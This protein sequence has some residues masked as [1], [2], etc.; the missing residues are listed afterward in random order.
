MAQRPLPPAPLRTLF[1]QVAARFP[2]H[3]MQRIRTPDG[4]FR[5]TYASPGMRETFGI[6]P[7]LVL[8]QREA[9]HSWVHPEDRGRF[10][11]ALHRSADH[12][13]TLDEEV[14][15]VGPDGGHKWVRSIGTPRRLADGTVVWDG[16]AL[17]VTERRAAAEAL[18]RAVV[19]ARAAEAARWEAERGAGAM[20]LASLLKLNDA[21]G[22][23]LAILPAE[24][25]R[26][27][28]CASVRESLARLMAQRVGAADARAPGTAPRLTPR[29]QTVLALL[30]AGLTNRQIAARLG[31]TEGTVK[32]HV[33]AVLKRLGV[34]NRTEAALRAARG[35]D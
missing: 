30:G 17:D 1:D 18:E 2:G 21:V 7:E 33:A 29:Q 32:L 34:S 35:L 3:T 4:R 20:P 12:L 11:T 15:V 8:S 28:Q 24:L 5:Y 13:E 14:R 31:T 16:I 10:V 27:D 23:L 6:D 19:L 26:T 25:A 9:D 22:Q